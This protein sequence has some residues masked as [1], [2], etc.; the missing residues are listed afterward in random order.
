MSCLLS[1]GSS[2]FICKTETL[3]PTDRVI[4]RRKV[5]DTHKALVLYTIHLLP[6]I[7]PLEQAPVSRKHNFS[8]PFSARWHSDPDRSDLKEVRNLI[9]KFSPLVEE[10]P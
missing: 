4:V 9:A 5:N 2:L 8:H 7:P 3:N 10:K 6:T 1:A